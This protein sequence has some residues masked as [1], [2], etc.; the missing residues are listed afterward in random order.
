MVISRFTLPLAQAAR[1]LLRER[2]SGADARQRPATAS[3]LLCRHAVHVLRDRFLVLFRQQVFLLA[4]DEVRTVDGEEALALAHVLVGRIRKDIPNPAGKARL[5]IR[6]PLLVDLNVAG[7]LQFIAYFFH[8]HDSRRDADLL[9]T[10]R[11]HL[12]GRE[13]GLS[14]ARGLRFAPSFCEGVSGPRATT[15]PVVGLRDCRRPMT[16]QHIP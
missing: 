7:S 1:F 5:H 16:P 8:L 10:L 3:C 2:R 15:G 14:R 9:H 6:D 12:N 4:A 13:R 11:R